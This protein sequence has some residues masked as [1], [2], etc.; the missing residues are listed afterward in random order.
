MI[1]DFFDKVSEAGTDGVVPLDSAR[2]KGLNA[3]EVATIHATHFS[4]VGNSEA[5]DAVIRYLTDQKANLS[6]T[7]INTN[8]PGHLH[9]YDNRDN[10]VGLDEDGNIEMEIDGAY[11]LPYAN[12]TGDHEIIWVPPE[13][14]GVQFE[15]VAD[16]EGLVGLEIGQGLGDGLHFFSYEDVEVVPGSTITIQ[17][18]PTHPEGRITH[19]DGQTISLSPTFSE[20]GYGIEGSGYS[21]GGT[22]SPAGSKLKISEIMLVCAC[23]QGWLLAVGGLVGVILLRQRQPENKTPVLIL[24]IAVIVL[25]ISTCLLG[26]YMVFGRSPNGSNSEGSNSMNPLPTMERLSNTPEPLSQGTSEIPQTAIAELTVVNDSSTVICYVLIS[27]VESDDW[28]DD[29][30]GSDE[31]LLSGNSRKFQLPEGT[32][33]LAVLDCG[34]QILAEE[35]DVIITGLM[36]WTIQN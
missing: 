33:H 23:V 36:E 25:T 8:S 15:F 6:G 3:R 20:I 14:E 21:S 27:P 17:V 9:V 26:A 34:D 16:E 19:P 28:G 13:V 2:G 5:T 7:Q 29:W 35:Y 10:H 32:Y 31:M 12:A 11:Y 1:E 18:H 24:G 30:L 4:I 22:D